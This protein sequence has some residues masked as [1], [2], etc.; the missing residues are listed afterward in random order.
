MVPTC[1]N[2][3]LDMTF[4]K[5]VLLVYPPLIIG[6]CWHI[7]HNMSISSS[8]ST[9]LHC[10]TAHHIT[11]CAWFSPSLWS[12]AL[13][14]RMAK[15]AQGGSMPSRI[16]ARKSDGCRL[17]AWVKRRLFS[18]DMTCRHSKG[19]CSVHQCP[20]LH[21]VLPCQHY[22]CSMEKCQIALACAASGKHLFSFH[23]QNFADPIMGVKIS[24]CAW[25]LWD[26]EIRHERPKS[27]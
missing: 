1:P 8:D 16:L 25:F 22:G 14:Q 11:A 4:V 9:L 26:S 2:L 17:V 27:T 19:M 20:T 12:Q 18:C 7:G 5:R 21:F 10:Y 24:G 3:V 23:D 13:G 6:N 15:A